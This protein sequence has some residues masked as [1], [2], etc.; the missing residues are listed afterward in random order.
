M[1]NNVLYNHHPTS[2]WH[3][4]GYELADDDDDDDDVLFSDAAAL[5]MYVCSFSRLI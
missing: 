2:C 5:F 3:A 4:D 1:L